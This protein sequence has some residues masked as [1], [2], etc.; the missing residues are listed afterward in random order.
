MSAFSDYLENELLDHIL[1]NETW[2]PP[3][4][5]W[6]ALFTADNGLEAGTITG[7]V[8]GGAYARMEVGGASGRTF[9]AAVAGTT[10]NDQDIQFITASADWG[11]VTHMAIMD[12]SSAGNVLY[13]GA[14]TLAKTVNNGDT[15]KYNAGDLDVAHD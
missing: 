15:F 13:H 5:V 8:T 6:I 7:E 9:S 11:T 4:S 12:A 1:R 2:A 3:A 14:L 10:D